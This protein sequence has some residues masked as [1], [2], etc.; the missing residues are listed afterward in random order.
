MNCCKRCMAL[1]SCGLYLFASV[2][3]GQDS[4]EKDIVDSIYNLLDTISEP[5]AKI[6]QLH[7]QATYLYDFAP[8]TKV[9]LDTALGIA[10]KFKLEDEVAISHLNLMQY[11]VVNSNLDSADFYYDSAMD[12]PIVASDPVQRSDFFMVKA[13][14]LK[15]QGNVKGALEY[16]LDALSLLEQPGLLQNLEDSTKRI[17]IDRSR[18][19]LHNNLANLYKDIQDFNAAVEHYDR[20]FDILMKLQEPAFAGTV[21]MNKAGL[22]YDHAIYDTAYQLQMQA[23][24]L[25]IEGN[26]SERSIA[27]SDLNIGS[28]LL[29]LGKFSQAKKYIDGALKDFIEIENPAGL[30][31]AYVT[32]GDLNVKT[33]NYQAAIEDCEQGKAL[34]TKAGILDLQQKAC[35][36]LFHAYKATGEFQKALSN[37]VQLKLLSDSLRNDANTKYITQLEMQYEFDKEEEKRMVA[38]KEAQLLQAEKDRRNRRAFFILAILL[39]ISLIVGYLIYQNYQIK[40]KSESEL[41]E[42][43][44]EISKALKEKELLLGEIHHRVKNNLQVISSLLRLQSRYI[45]DDVALNAISAGQSRVQSMALLHENLYQDDNFTGV[46]MQKYFDRL[47][48]GLFSALNISPD[49]IQLEKD[50]APIELDVDFVV[51]IGLITNELITNSLKHA[52]SNQSQGLLK[53]KLYVEENKLFLEVSDNGKGMSPD[54]FENRSTSFGHKLIK[55][56][57]LKLKAELKVINDGG[58]TVRLIT[59]DY[60]AN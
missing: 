44:D 30:T 10:E 31:N 20:S 23:R 52:F 26:A 22:Y 35:D 60:R 3:F 19:I 17:G 49:K 21:L 25:K 46:N 18:C 5:R 13:T 4:R 37:H 16:F 7:Q 14:I 42:K 53:V 58:T 12:L 59:S 36:C 27:M 29:G 6:L 40:K 48:N 9:F 28:A 45:E 47:I 32:R 33:A 41:S 38:E 15:N 43:N 39:V 57:A 54:F 2:S 1:L 8:F 24:E 51:P 56:F 50:I 11:H 55:A 34:A